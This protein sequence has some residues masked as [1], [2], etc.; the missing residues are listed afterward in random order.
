MGCRLFPDRTGEAGSFPNRTSGCRVVSKRNVAVGAVSR[1]NQW[2]VFFLVAPAQVCDL[3]SSGTVGVCQFTPHNQLPSRHGVNSADDSWADMGFVKRR[4]RVIVLTD[5]GV[6]QCRPV[7]GARGL[8]MAALP[9]Y[10][11]A[12]AGLLPSAHAGV[13]AR[14]GSV[15][16]HEGQ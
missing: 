11:C 3:S 12:S 4:V 6:E 16:R 2:Q 7:G 8:M 9:K 5:Q 15:T 13:A 1:Q 14:A 10:N